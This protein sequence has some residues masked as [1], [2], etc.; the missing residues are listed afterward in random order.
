MISM[1]VLTEWKGGNGSYGRMWTSGEIASNRIMTN[2]AK[3]D[4]RS[5]STDYR[6]TA[7]GALAS[8]LGGKSSE[9]AKESAR[10]KDFSDRHQSRVDRDKRMSNA[11]YKGAGKMYDRS[12]PLK[13]KRRK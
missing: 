12:L 6:N 7:Q 13:R 1:M 4:P 3:T 9:I 8:T 10:S 11:I 2:L 5:K